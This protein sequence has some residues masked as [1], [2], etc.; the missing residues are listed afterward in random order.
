MEKRVKRRD[1]VEIQAGEDTAGELEL[2]RSSSQTVCTLKTSTHH[3]GPC[4]ERHACPQEALAWGRH[5]HLVEF[6]YHKS[7]TT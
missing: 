3:S 7:I 6:R 2:L 5:S 4:S 1:T